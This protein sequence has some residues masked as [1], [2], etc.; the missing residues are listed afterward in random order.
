MAHIG[1]F[2]F[3]DHLVGASKILFDLLELAVL[4]DNCFEFGVLL[5]ELLETR[6][7]ADDLGRGEFVGHFLVAGV[8]LIEFFAES[9]YRHVKTFL[10]QI[11]S[12][13]RS[14]ADDG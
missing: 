9:E 13:G 14:V 6:G 10:Q 1:V 8:E 3:D 7:I 4:G 5:G 11:E 2:G 12:H